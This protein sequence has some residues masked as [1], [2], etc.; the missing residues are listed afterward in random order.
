MFRT[1]ITTILLAVV[2]FSSISDAW[3]F[4]SSNDDDESAG[5]GEEEPN[6][7][8]DLDSTNSD[9]SDSVSVDRASPPIPGSSRIIADDLESGETENDAGKSA[10]SDHVHPAPSRSGGGGAD[11]DPEFDHRAILGSA[12][13]AEQF[14]HLSPAEAKKRLWALTKLIDMDGNGEVTEEELQVS[15]QLATDKRVSADFCP[16]RNAFVAN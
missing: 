4:G 12:E 14:H 13:K 16:R 2:I 3:L 1:R 9:D 5:R 8:D 7:K 15:G 10:G 6:R 11:Q